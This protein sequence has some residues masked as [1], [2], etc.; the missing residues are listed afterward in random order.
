M[1]SIL[2]STRQPVGQVPAPAPAP[3]AAS[4]HAS[5]PNQGPTP[6]TAPAQAK[7][8]TV[9]PEVEGPSG[10]K[11]RRWPAAALPEI[12]G[13][14]ISPRGIEGKLVNIS[15]SGL[16]AECRDR[17]QTGSPVTIIFDGTFSPSRVRGSVARN[18]VASMSSDGGILY[19]VGI[20]FT[21]S[22]DL[23]HLAHENDGPAEP[24]AVTPPAPVPAP[25]PS[26]SRVVRNRW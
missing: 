14:R 4:A 16:L 18:C 3:A 5:V 12:T 7:A 9:V 17:L 20:A 10:R 19:H 1:L 24:P 23:S 13:I 26:P 22:I 8:E 25:S 15:Q 6:P 21:A 2:S 11:A